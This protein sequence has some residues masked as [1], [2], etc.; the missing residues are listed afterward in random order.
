MLTDA[1]RLVASR[2]YSWEELG[3]LF[4]FKPNYLSVAG[5]MVSCPGHHALLLITHPGGGKSFDYEDY[6]DEDSQDLIYTGRGKVGDQTASGANADVADNRKTL[7]V[8]QNVGVKQLCYLGEA[9]SVGHWP[10]RGIG[11]DGNERTI[12][13]FRLRFKSLVSAAVTTTNTEQQ[14]P[15]AAP[16]R[17]ARAFDTSVN[18]EPFA[19][20]GRR[21][22]PEDRLALQEQRARAHRAIL[23]HLHD[24]LAKAGWLELEEIRGAIDLRA[25]HASGFRV[26]FEA[27]SIDGNEVDQCRSALGQLLEYRFFYGE[28]DDRLCLVVDQPVSDARVRC[29][30]SLGVGVLLVAASGVTGIGTVGLD[31]MHG[32]A[33]RIVS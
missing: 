20:S 22:S 18:I 23:V 12:L 9:V 6:W 5:G 30:E 7:H 11:N 29:L 27:K 28:P 25:R 1:P 19:L 8:F 24:A 2:V 31:I 21:T 32:A 13:R 17:K 15:A 4:S 10:A 16:Q 14:R 3:A 26:I 33:A